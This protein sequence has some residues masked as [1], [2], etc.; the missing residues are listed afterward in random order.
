MKI[1]ELRNTSGR[2]IDRH[3]KTNPNKESRTCG[4]VLAPRV[5]PGP[6]VQ[7]YASNDLRPWVLRA[8]YARRTPLN[9]FFLS[10]RQY[11]R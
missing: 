7:V 2:E 1:V 11:T 4:I 10:Q 9:E 8:I 5:V 3:L 6:C